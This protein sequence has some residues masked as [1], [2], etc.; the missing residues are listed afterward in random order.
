MFGG[1]S[2][3]FN[4]NGAYLSTPNSPDWTFGSGDFT[5]DLWVRFNSLPVNGAYEALLAQ[6][7]SASPINLWGLYVYNNAGTYQW[8]FRVWSANSLVIATQKNAAVALQANTWYH[9]AVVRSG[10]S[11]YIFQNGIQC[12]T[13]D[14]YS[15]SVPGFAASVTI[16]TDLT[17]TGA[18]W[19]NGY[20]DELR[21][22]KGVARWTTNFT[23]P[24][25]AYTGDSNTVLLLHMDGADGS[26][27]FIDSP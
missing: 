12:G 3:L 1:A 18:S 14:S 27:T 4:G 9:V 21:I 6:V 22:S 5:I 19:L 20:I 25:T 23:P 26:T 17:G 8:R 2:G 16:G 13:T 24:T 10:N 15:A 7:Q 11:W